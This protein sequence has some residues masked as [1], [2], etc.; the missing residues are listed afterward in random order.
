MLTAMFE[1]KALQ[2]FAECVKKCAA[3]RGRDVY[4]D[5]ICTNLVESVFWSG[6]VCPTLTDYDTSRNKANVSKTEDCELQELKVYETH[7]FDTGKKMIN[8][9]VLTRR[10]SDKEAAIW[11]GKY[12]CDILCVLRG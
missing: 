2:S 12:S 8:S 1:K 6:G 9:S 10:E 3:V 11:K 7:G 4:T 5:D